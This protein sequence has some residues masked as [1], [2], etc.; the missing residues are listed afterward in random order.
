MFLN[1]KNKKVIDAALNN[2][3]KASQYPKTFREDTGSRISK[4][5]IGPQTNRNTHH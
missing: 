2:H 1:L 5:S 4:E 3:I